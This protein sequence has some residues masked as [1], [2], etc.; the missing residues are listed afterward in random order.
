MDWDH[1]ERRLIVELTEAGRKAVFSGASRLVFNDFSLDF[2]DESGHLFFGGAEGMIFVDLT[3]TVV[4]AMLGPGVI[5][6]RWTD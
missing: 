1:P 2:G 5:E 3:A 4:E 6:K